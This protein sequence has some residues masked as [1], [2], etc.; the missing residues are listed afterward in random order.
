VRN[1]YY[2]ISDVHLGLYPL[3][4]SREREKKLNRW[5]DTIKDDAA[6][7]YLVGDIF[8]FWHEHK[9]VVPKGFVRFLGRLAELTDLG[10]KVYFFSGNHDIWAY[11]YFEDELNIP[12]IHHPI[13][14]EIGGKKFFIGHGDGVG[15]GDTGYKLLK[16]VFRNRVLQWIFARLH[17]NFAMWLGKSWSKNSRYSKGIVAEEFVGEK[18]L[19]IIFARE[20]L[21]QKTF[22]YF[23]FGH[24]HI[25][26]DLKLKDDS[27][28]I[29][30]G[31]WI[32]SFTYAVF[33]GN[34][35]QLKQF[36]GD[37]KNIRRSL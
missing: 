29:N 14:R 31:D 37:G 20:T 18:E 4:N 3:E 30:L 22:D 35:L 24:R 21:N 6:E 16:W 8:D 1:K 11:G 13:E 32:Y 17:P 9:H 15:P 34:D 28:I 33:D 19:Q 10:V 26:W 12:I 36:E 25:P 23:I 27:R 7:L 2:F 5:L